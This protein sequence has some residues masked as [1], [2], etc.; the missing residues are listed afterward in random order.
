MD[1]LR[2]FFKM[3]PSR[4]RDAA[5]AIVCRLLL[6]L[7][8]SCRVCNMLRGMGIGYM[9]GLISAAAQAVLSAYYGWRF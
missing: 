1:R 3:A 5:F 7:S 9:L 2:L 6:P 4:M 8:T